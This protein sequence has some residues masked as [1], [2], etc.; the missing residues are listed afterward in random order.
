M[1]GVRM[2]GVNG[3]AAGSVISLCVTEIWASI[4]VARILGTV[5]SKI[6][7]W[8]FSGRVVAAVFVAVIVVLIAK[9]VWLGNVSP[10][11]RL[12]WETLLYIVLVVAGM[13]AMGIH[14][15][16]L[17]IVRYFLHRHK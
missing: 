17:S 8:A 16:G 9:E 2:F 12:V 7:H 14:R 5:P 4:V 3:A 15:R 1:L 11:G 13:V 6:V 10:F